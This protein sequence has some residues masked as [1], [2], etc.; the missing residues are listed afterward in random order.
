MKYLTLI[1]AIALLHQYQREVK[2]VQHEGRAVRYIEVTK[3]DVATANRLAHEVLGR[4]LDELPPQTRRLLGLLSEMVGKQAEAQGL[5]RSDV[6]FT[7]RDVREHTGWGH[8]QLKIHLHRLAELEYLLVHPVGRGQSFLYELA[9]AG[10]AESDRPVLAGLIDVETL[11]SHEYDADRSGL[12]G[13]RSGCGR[14][15]V[16]AWSG[17]GRGPEMGE[18][19]RGDGSLLAL[20]AEERRNA[21][22]GS[23]EATRSYVPQPPPLVAAAKAGAR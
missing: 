21:R 8:T 20:D 15:V 2:T 4:S 7:R 17:G 12:E 18:N 23:G 5:E 1:R 6:R 14:P 11:E 16:G 3:A 10:S 22:L 19:D 13:E 9:Y